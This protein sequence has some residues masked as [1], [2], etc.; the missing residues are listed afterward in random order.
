MILI[1]STSLTILWY[2]GLYR[3]TNKKLSN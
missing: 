1:L 2:A 3:R